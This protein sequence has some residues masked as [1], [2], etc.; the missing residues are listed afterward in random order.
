MQTTYIFGHKTPDTDSVCSSISLSY[1]KNK[2]GENYRN[3][4]YLLPLN[5]L[6]KEEL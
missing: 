1:L 4:Y 6:T 2:I 5:E 3:I